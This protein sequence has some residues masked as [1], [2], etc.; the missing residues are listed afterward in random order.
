MARPERLRIPHNPDPDGRFH[1][2]GRAAD[3]RQFIA[4]VTGAFQYDPAAH[5]QR[6]D[7][8]K[9]WQAVVHTFSADGTHLATTTRLGGHDE[10]GRGV[11][12]SKAWGQMGALFD[13]L[14]LSHATL[15]DVWVAPFE[16]LQDGI[17]Y[18]LIYEVFEEDGE[19]DEYV[20]LEPNDVMFHP[21]WDSGEFST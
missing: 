21:P 7:G 12:G 15:G 13:E 20:M 16:V 10:D 5:G 18:G 2:V 8:E 3:G 14:G 17:L 9:T 11:A 19:R 1:H 6:W 4:F